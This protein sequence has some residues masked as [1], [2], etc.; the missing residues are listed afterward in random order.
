MGELKGLLYICDSNCFSYYVTMWVMNEYGIGES[1][2]KV[3]HID[4]LT[5]PYPW[6]HALC[7][8]VKHFEEGAAVLLYHSLDCL[9]YYD[10]DKYGVKDFRIHGSSSESFDVIP[11]IP[12]LISLKDVVK[13]ENIEVLNIHSR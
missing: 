9:T 13:G 1:W 6:R 4:T 12:S 10:P 7:L 2:T 8:P 5:N 11:H 3:Y